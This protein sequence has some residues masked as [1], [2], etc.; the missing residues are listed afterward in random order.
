M[1][2]FH[3]SCLVFDPYVFCKEQNVQSLGIVMPV[4]VALLR[5][6]HWSPSTDS[7]S[8]V[9]KYFRHSSGSPAETGVC[10]C[11]TGVYGHS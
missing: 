11:K 1:L 8:L 9:A 4:E 6:F 5:F 2:L 3:A 10:I 7:L